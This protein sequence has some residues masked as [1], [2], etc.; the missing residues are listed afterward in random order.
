L[1]IL[2]ST[3]QRDPNPTSADESPEPKF[4]CRAKL[5]SRDNSAPRDH[6]NEWNLREKVTNTDVEL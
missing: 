6:T 3:L 5:A 1:S 4:R 2:F